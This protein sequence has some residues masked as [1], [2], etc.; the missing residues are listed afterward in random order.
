MDYDKESFR[1]ERMPG[2]HDANFPWAIKRADHEKPL[3]MVAISKD[4]FGVRTHFHRGRTGPCRKDG[5]EACKAKQLS[6]WS[7]YLLAVAAKDNSKI[8]FEFTPPAATQLDEAVKSYGSLRGLSLIATRTSN[9]PNGRVSVQVKGMNGN[10]HRLPADEDVWPIL[11]HLWG[12]TEQAIPEYQEFTQ[13]GLAE[14]ERVQH[15]M[16]EVESADENQ[17]MRKRASDLAGQIILPL[18]CNVQLSNSK[19]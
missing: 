12:L 11:S 10:A 6:R 8:V 15:A 3:L 5:C 17:W 2:S 14:A 18:D 9:R 4:I 19:H 7:G 16:K 13:E 1:I